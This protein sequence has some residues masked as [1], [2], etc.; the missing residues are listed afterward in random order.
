VADVTFTATTTRLSALD[1]SFL[2]LESPSTHMH[3]GWSAIFAAPGDGDRP[4]VQALRDRVASRLDDVRWCRW[5]LQ[6]APLGL[7]EPRWADDRDFDL[8][9]H[10][11]ALSEPAEP[12]GYDTFATLRDTLLSEPLD[13]SRPLWQ[14]FLIPRLEDGRVGLI[15][16]VHHALV[17][18][19]AALQV[20]GLVAD[21]LPEAA[22]EPFETG[23]PAGEQSGWDFA[24]EE[25]AQVTADAWRAVRGTA[26]AAA[27]PRTSARAAIRSARKVL[28]AAREDVLPAAPSCLLNVP[29]GP[30]RALVGYHASAAELRAARLGGGT[31]NDVG[32]AVVAGALRGLALRRGEPPAAPWKAMVPIS[33]RRPHQAGP[34]NQISMVNIQLP[35]HLGSA[36][37]RR[38]WVR[39]QTQRLKASDRAQGTQMLYA[40]GGLLPAPLR[41]PVTKAMASP[42]IFNVTISQ[43]P[44][45]RGAVHLLGCELQDVYSVVPIADGHALAIGMVRYR[46]ELFFGCYADPDAL[47]EV[48]ALPDL[49]RSEMHALAGRAPAR[50]SAAAV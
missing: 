29:I 24:R 30:R 3:V 48:V 21:G 17:D 45:P 8:A 14:I 31:R 6:P 4:T 40:A 18:G 35:V 33:M 49:L 25:L 16:K 12:V 37:E 43:S 7:A 13:R 44:G 38:D 11:L 46:D 19:I 36:Q 5:R 2:R 34:G 50:R 9:R 20:V 41:T 1:G 39:A 32:L 23:A 26:G 42:R 10:V 22:D 27:R 15:G 47:P 28:A